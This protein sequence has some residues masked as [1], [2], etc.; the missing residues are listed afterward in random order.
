MHIVASDI[1]MAAHYSHTRTDTFQERLEVWKDAPPRQHPETQNASDDA[2]SIDDKVSISTVDPKYLII[3]V[4]IEKLTGKTITIVEMGELEGSDPE[5]LEHLSNTAASSEGGRAGWGMR[6]A[7][8]ETHQENQ[9]VQFTAQGV[10]RTRDGKEITFNVNVMLKSNYLSEH[11]VSLRAGDARRVDPLVMHFNGSAA[12]LT[13]MKFAFD[14]DADGKTDAIPFVTRGSG[15]LA[16]DKNGD[17]TINDGSELFGPVTGNGF[18][19]L[20]AY[21][22]DGNAWIDEGDEIYGKLLIWMKDGEGKDSLVSLKEKGIGAL[23][24]GNLQSKFDIKNPSQGLQG[25][26]KRFGIYLTESN[27][28]A[29]IIQ[30]I[31][32]VV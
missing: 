32:L 14:L 18:G 1:A 28:T 23:H 9:E 22:N 19:E 3:K 20:A 16:L 25:E 10:I 30:Q 11:H 26:V 31:D 8:S 4:L 7:A 29:G 5:S 24:L 13:D 6:Y 15:F 12:E 17:G 27:P 2:S 21:D